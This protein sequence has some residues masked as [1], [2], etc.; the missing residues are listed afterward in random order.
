MT[1]LKRK[2]QL[3]NLQILD[4]EAS[5]EYKTTIRDIWKVYCQLVPPNIHCRNSAKRAIHTFKANFLSILSGIAEDFPLKLW[6]LLIAQT[7]MT[8]NLLR[9]STLKP[10]TLV[11][12]NFNGPTSCNY[13]TLGPLGCK[14]IM[15]FKKKLLSF[16][17]FMRKGW[18]K[19]R[20]VP[21]A[22]LVPVCLHKG[23]QGS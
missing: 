10:D 23:Y 19:Y 20:R 12:G 3:V 16:L 13:S 15:H 22:L 11:W 9:Q 14:V 7:E 18:M 5:V 4:N 2:N 21:G 6:D 8:L 1:G 17:G